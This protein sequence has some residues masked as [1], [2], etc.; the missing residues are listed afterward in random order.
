MSIPHNNNTALVSL[1]S[2]SV[3]IIFIASHKSL[4]STLGW[5]M[6]ENNFSWN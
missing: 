1:Q 2:V 4:Y 6:H 3:K 5:M